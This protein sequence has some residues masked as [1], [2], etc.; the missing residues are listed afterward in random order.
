MSEDV[1]ECL[2]AEFEAHL[3]HTPPDILQL[4]EE[5]EWADV[6]DKAA[7]MAVY[8]SP[9]TRAVLTDR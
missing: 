5:H 3:A 9:A 8:P 1:R 7:A 6:D 4:F 2:E